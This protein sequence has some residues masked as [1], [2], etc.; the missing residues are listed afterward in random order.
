MNRTMI[1]ATNTMSQLQHKMDII[2]HNL[3]NVQTNGYKRKESY[4]NELL[5]QEFNNQRHDKL[6]IGRITSNGIRQGTGAKLS[7]ARLV[8]NQGSIK[9]TGRDLDMALT[10][11]DL[12]FK[13]RVDDSTQFTRDGSFYLNP[14]TPNS[15]D[16]MLVT[17]SGYPVL[18]ENDQPIVVNGPIKNLSVSDKGLLTVETDNAGTQSFGIGMISIQKPEYMEQKTGNTLGLTSEA[19]ALGINEEDIFVDVTGGIRNNISLQP[20]ALENSNVDMSKEMTDLINVQRHYQFQARSV[21]MA[22]QMMG[23][24]NGIR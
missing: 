8:L 16:L 22:D 17:S 9:A 19:Q 13:V 10:K 1:T 3:A 6:E 5:F 18:D 2:G 24:I 23:L 20:R 12:F 21:S 11:E 14:I 4:F 15:D 7:Q